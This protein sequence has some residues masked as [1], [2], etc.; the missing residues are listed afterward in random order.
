MDLIKI[1]NKMH[2]IPRIKKEVVHTVAA[3]PYFSVDSE[4]I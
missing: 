1:K 3:I 2:E 4:E